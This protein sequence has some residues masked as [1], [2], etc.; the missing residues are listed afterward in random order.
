[1]AC[2][3]FICTILFGLSD[4]SRLTLFKDFI[5]KMI[6]S[7]FQGKCKKKKN[8]PFPRLWPQLS[9]WLGYFDDFNRPNIIVQI[10]VLHA[11]YSVIGIQIIFNDKVM[12]TIYPMVYIVFTIA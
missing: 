2:N 5:M 7:E 12:Y 10:N 9:F 1:M 4:S 8:K 3:T 6:E 11:S